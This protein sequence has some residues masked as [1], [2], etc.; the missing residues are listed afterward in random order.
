M[1]N[2]CLEFIGRIDHQ[3]KVRGY[4]VE[5]GEIEA[6]LKSHPMTENAVVA[7]VENG[8]GSNKLIAYVAPKC[9]YSPEGMLF[10]KDLKSYIKAIL[11]EYMMPA[12][13]VVLDSVPLSPNGKVDRRALPAP[14]VGRAEERNG[15]LFPR[16]PVEEIVIAIFQ[17]VLKLDRVGRKEN[18]FEL[19]GHSLLATQ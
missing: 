8:S 4:R 2:G 13:F 15:Y 7:A 18:F 17:R 10:P 12:S 19:G 14:E 9:E 5:L 1:L 16:T 11:P 6:A 3:I